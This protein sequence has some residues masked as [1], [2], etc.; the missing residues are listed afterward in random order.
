[1][2]GVP[3]L[4]ERNP[5]TNKV[6]DEYIPIRAAAM[7]KLVGMERMP[8]ADVRLTVR[9][10][11][12]VRLEVVAKPTREQR[13]VGILD[14]WYR[15][16]ADAG[17][18]H[19]LFEAVE[20]TDLT[21]LPDGEWAGEAIGEKIMHNPLSIEGHTVVFSSLF[22]WRDHIAAAVPPELGRTP[23]E[24]DDL[25][26]WLGQTNSRYADREGIPI[27]GVVWWYEDTPIAQIRAKDFRNLRPPTDG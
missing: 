6:V 12:C 13:N 15:D 25:R 9:N 4:F 20:N 19:W 27:D 18:D 24:F 5:R 16:T 11:T 17:A 7:H 3:T 10:G 22:P 14:P 2:L 23:L 26:Y 8:G 21:S 1:M